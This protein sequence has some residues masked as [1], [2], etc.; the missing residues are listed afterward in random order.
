M[1]SVASYPR[2]DL[3]NTPVLRRWTLKAYAG[4]WQ[5]QFSNCICEKVC[6][7]HAGDD[8]YA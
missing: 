2:V 8:V 4:F 7:A 3:S 6:Y 5:Q 1:S